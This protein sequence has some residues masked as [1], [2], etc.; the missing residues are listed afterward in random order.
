MERYVVESRVVIGARDESGTSLLEVVVALLLI[1]L[2]TLA[3]VPMF[4]SAKGVNASGADISSLSA[5]AAARMETLRAEPF[6]HLVAGGS[7]ASSV[8]GYSD[9]SDP[10]VVVRWQVVDGGGPAGTKTIRLLALEVSEI[11]EQASTVELTTLRAR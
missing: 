4:V 6:H 1:A 8:A 10:K 5:I 2:G 9:T 11:S 7:L 3:V